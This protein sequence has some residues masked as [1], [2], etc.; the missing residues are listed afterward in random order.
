MK[1][2]IKSLLAVGFV[3]SLLVVGMQTASA[4]A[5]A[6]TS[7]SA[8]PSSIQSGE[9]T[10]LNWQSTNATS[11]QGV[12][13]SANWAGQRG[14]SG[15]FPV[16]GLTQ[17]TTFGIYCV[18]SQN[19]A[20]SIVYITI[21]V[22][23]T[24]PPPS[25][26]GSGGAPVVTS[27]SANPSTLPAGNYS[28]IT[29]TSSNAS[30]CVGTNGGTTGWAGSNKNPSGSFNTPPLYQ[31]TTFGVY[32]S[33]NGVN[34]QTIYITVTVTQTSPQISVNLNASDTS[35]TQG[36]TSQLSWTV[37]G[38]TG[39]CTAN[40]LPSTSQWSSSKA[41]NGG[42]VTVSPTQTTKYTL[43]CNGVAD[44][45]WVTVTTTPPP[46]CPSGMIGTPPNCTWPPA[47][48]CPSGMIGTPPNCTYPT[49][50]SG[51]IGTPPNCTW[52]PAP[53]APNVTLTANPNSVAYNG[54]TVL[55]W[56]VSNAT[57]CVANSNPATSW[58]N[59]KSTAGGSQTVSGLTGTTF[60]NIFCTGP[61][62]S[63]SATIT[64]TVGAQPP[65]PTCPS[66]QIGTYPNCSYPTCPSGMVGTYPNCSNPPAPTC[67]AGMIGT[68]PNCTYPP[69]PTCL[70]GMI[71]TY[72]N[73][74]YPP[75]PTCLSGQIGTY[76]NCS[77]PPAPQIITAITTFATNI[78]VNS[79]R[80]NGLG[81]QNNSNSALS[82][83][84]EWGTTRAL[85]STTQSRFIGSGSSNPYSESV[86]NQFRANTTYFY[87]AVVT[88]QNGAVA[89]G[90]IVS[91]RTGG[92]VVLGVA[93]VPGPSIAYRNTTLVTN[94]N[95]E[96]NVSKPSLV[97][98]DTNCNNQI[99]QRGDTIQCTITWK[100]ATSTTNLTGV[101]LRVGFPKELDFL[102]STTGVFSSVDNA[103]IV[104]IGNLAPGQEG[105]M[106]FTTKVRM[107]A[108]FKKIVIASQ[109]VYSY[110]GDK[111]D[112]KQE[113]VFS[114]SEHTIV[115]NLTGSIAGATILSGTNGF[116]P[117]SLAGWL[118]LL[119][120]ILLILLAI[121]MVSNSSRP[122]VVVTPPSNGSMH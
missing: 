93:T 42:P 106:T 80:L 20:S 97:F 91:F 40:A 53:T 82:G 37:T 101:L 76:P 114:Y 109:A 29:W 99:V 45:V 56:T 46:T 55:A 21:T 58:A 33:S 78:G 89:Y 74:T 70:A 83:Y 38:W 85:G 111:G 32:C 13:G 41:W 8:N 7:F 27:L 110:M 51:M 57:S 88:N 66:G 81:L 61:G 77:Y 35:I 65:A 26:G 22:S 2:F 47:P 119:L 28:V 75:A 17:T 113:E 19:Q 44:Y 36:E 116:M 94:T 54:S 9:S 102:Q 50:P 6:V 87:R 52:P 86:I 48:T 18:N 16:V 118:L 103:V 72:P 62:G 100:N 112:L 1:K 43:T 30:F 15:S 73:C 122:Q 120:L 59:N 71:G 4:V 90:D 107:D 11:C 12:G 96:T 95:I 39:S 49:C 108:E 69:A 34:S 14:F 5:P 31:N 23:N 68:Y 3:F 98:L 63:D 92:G 79:A 64:V 24:P 10:T 105:S 104:D 117:S 25:S 84:F 60:F 67:L 115:D 121:K